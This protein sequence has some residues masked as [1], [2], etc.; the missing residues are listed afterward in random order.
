MKTENQKRKDRE[1]KRLWRKRN[2]ASARRQDLRARA[3]R[4]RGW[5]EAIINIYKLESN[6]FKCEI[7]GKNLE[8]F[9]GIKNGSVYFDH[10]RESIKIKTQ[11]SCWMRDHSPTDKNIIIFAKERFGILCNPCNTRIPTKNRKDWV[12]KLVKYVYNRSC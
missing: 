8:M 6:N 3:K 12:E 10:R 9:S 11:P 7:C 2:P 4:E 5:K 1:Q